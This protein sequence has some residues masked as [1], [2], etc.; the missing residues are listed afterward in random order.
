M[1]T[2]DDHG[3]DWSD[4]QEGDEG[5]TCKC[6]FNGTH[7]ECAAARI[8]DTRTTP[9]LRRI[10]SEFL[11]KHSKSARCTSVAVHVDGELCHCYYDADHAEVHGHDCGHPEH[12]RWHIPDASGVVL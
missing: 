12:R 5:P 1:S 8:E 6:G 2:N 11:P 4:W 10:M 9:E 3:P 7:E